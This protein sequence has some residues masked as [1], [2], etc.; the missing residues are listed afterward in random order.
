MAMSGARTEGWKPGL[1]KQVWRIRLENDTYIQG[2]RRDRMRRGTDWREWGERRPSLRK[3]GGKEIGKTISIHSL[4]EAQ[5]E[6]CSSCVNDYYRLLC[7]KPAVVKL[8]LSQLRHAQ[9]GT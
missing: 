1:G 6:A 3:N 5:R 8:I 7:C 2:Q 9:A 4:Q